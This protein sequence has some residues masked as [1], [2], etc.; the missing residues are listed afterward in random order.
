MQKYSVNRNNMYW[1]QEIWQIMKE[2]RVNGYK[3]NN[4]SNN[5][6]EKCNMNNT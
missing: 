4:L 6:Y 5:Q 2:E 3:F 1:W